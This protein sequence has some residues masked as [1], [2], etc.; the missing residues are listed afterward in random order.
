M[1]NRKYANGRDLEYATVHILEADGYWVMRAPGSKGKVDVLAL[2]PGEILMVQ[3]KLDGYLTPSERTGLFGL[4]A[5]FGA[6][7]L[8]SY[9]HKPSARAARTV[10][11]D[12]LVTPIARCDWT[13]DH[14]LEAVR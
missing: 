10:A 7:P 11:F 12:R 14:G 13:P 3:C 6:V 1:P 2:K 9:W 8:V 4:A 5:M